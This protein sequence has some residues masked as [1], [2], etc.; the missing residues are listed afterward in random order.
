MHTYD[1]YT[2]ILSNEKVAED[3]YLLCCEC[4]E[5]A[6]NAHPGQFV[7]VLISNGT[8]LLLRR[9]FTIYTVDDIHISMLYQ[10]IGE[11]TRRLSE[12]P[13]GASIQVLDRLVIHL[14]L[15]TILILRF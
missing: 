10:I 1:T 2:T 15:L 6:Q 8:G 14:T 3:H 12:L 7:H 9:P 5:I 4:S 11:G 13:R